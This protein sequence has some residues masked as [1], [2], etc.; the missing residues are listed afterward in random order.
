MRSESFTTR[1]GSRSP[2][3]LL[4]GAGL[5]LLLCLFVLLFSHFYVRAEHYFYFWDIANYWNLAGAETAAFR[6]S[7]VW[8]FYSVMKSLAVDYNRVFTV[9][10]LPILA[11]FGNSR[12]VFVSSLALVYLVPFAL[13]LG[14]IASKLIPYHRRAVFWSTAVLAVLTPAIWAPTLRGWPDVGAAFLIALAIWVHLEEGRFTRTARIFL[15][16]FLAVAA[17]LFRRQYAYDAVAIYGALSLQA[18]VLFAEQARKSWRKA[19]RQILDSVVY[20]GLVGVV[21]IFTLVLIGWPFL[22]HVLGHSYLA[23]YS[24]YAESLSEVSRSYLSGF[25]WGLWALAILG[26]VLGIWTRVLSSS[27]TLVVL[28]FGAI[29]ALEWIVVVRQWGPQYGLHFALVVVLGVVSLGWTIWARTGGIARSAILTALALFLVLNFVNAVVPAK[30]ITNEQLQSVFT[31][32]YPPLVRNDYNTVAQ[33]IAYLRTVTKGKATYVVAS[34]SVLNPDMVKNAERI[35]YGRQAARLR[36]LTVPEIDSRDF[37]PLEPLLKA[38]FVVLLTPFQHHLAVKNQEV[39]KTVYDAFT[40]HWAISRDFAALPARFVLENGTVVHVYRRIR[41]TSSETALQTLLA[42]QERVR[43]VPG[44]QTGWLILGQLPQSTVT[45]VGN[46]TYSLKTLLFGTSGSGATTSFAYSKALPKQARVSGA[47][48][49]GDDRCSTVAL[50]FLLVGRQ[51]GLITHVADIV[52]RA[53]DSPRFDSPTFRTQGTTD[54]MLNISRTN[55]NDPAGS[56]AVTI[57]DLK[58]SGE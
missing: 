22:F 32:N 4:T 42:I 40:K 58:V 9:P 8:A 17:M 50:H 55:R 28:F 37:Y 16:G 43:A 12:A 45:Q 39:M 48:T 52:H 15:I 49:F 36:V 47:I 38:R 30:W 18:I 54:L 29:S 13:V 57:N 1:F 46:D 2:R 3:R 7:P 10:L 21:S 24:S 19:F 56:C 25:G 35:L 27:P 53:E 11:A 44:G 5:F 31:P 26:F 20:V 33:L 14:A 41:T 6:A 23:L 51:G 34:N